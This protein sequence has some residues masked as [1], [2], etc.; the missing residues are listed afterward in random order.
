MRSAGLRTRGSIAATGNQ[1]HLTRSSLK[2]PRVF[3]T[4]TEGNTYGIVGRYE[5]GPGGCT[6]L[7]YYYKGISYSRFS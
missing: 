6:E 2:K 4:T 1:R 7:H 5:R 3:G